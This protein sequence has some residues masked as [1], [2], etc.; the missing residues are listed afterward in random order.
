MPPIPQMRPA[1]RRDP[2]RPHR[3][4]ALVGSPSL[5]LRAAAAVVFIFLLS[6]VLAKI[7]VRLLPTIAEAL[8]IF[9]AAYRLPRRCLA[10]LRRWKAKARAS[11]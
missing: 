1:E 6:A 9:G 8:P 3:T 7:G 11:S 2:G 5:V 4:L 10:A